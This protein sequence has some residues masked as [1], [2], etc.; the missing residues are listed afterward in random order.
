MVAAKEG[1]SP[2]M[3]K[4]LVL[5]LLLLTAAPAKAASPA[6]ARTLSGIGIVLISVKSP[7]IT[8]FKEAALGRIATLD[9]SALPQSPSISP[10]EGFLPAI[11]TAKKGGWFKILY[12]DGEREGWI[13]G[14]SSY[15]FYRWKELLRNRQL[16][17]L[18]GLK[19]E[20]Y[21]LRQQPDF[22]GVALEPVGKGVTV[23]ALHTDGEWISVRTDSKKAGWLRWCDDNS[24]LAISLQL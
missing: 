4:A 5:C 24:R 20:Y 16:Q 18:G 9:A 22:S 15:Q 21:Q 6:K 14:R 3:L 13:E 2:G 12:D 7:Q 8:L 17:L 23:T 19:K 10:P 11:V 1:I